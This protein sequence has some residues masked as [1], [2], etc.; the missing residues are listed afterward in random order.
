MKKITLLLFSSVL[1]LLLSAQSFKFNADEFTAK[2][3]TLFESAKKRFA[4]D[5]G[6]KINSKCGN[7]I[8][9]YA[10]NTQFTEGISVIV[11]DNDNIKHHKTEFTIGSDL[12]EAK[13]I[14]ERMRALIK[15]NMP[16]KFAEKETYEGEYE[17]YKIHYY[18]FDSEIFAQTAKQPS[19]KIGIRKKDDKYI[20]ELM[21]IE[22]VFK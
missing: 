16:A 12:A 2:V 19:A 22:P 18:E 4:S 11:I 20:I 15:A 21:F 3:K 10:A 17:G 13:N 7:F 1:S 6:E 5:T 8:S 14:Y 9:C